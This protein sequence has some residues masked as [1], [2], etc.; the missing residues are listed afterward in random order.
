MK[1]NIDKGL[2]FNGLVPFPVSKRFCSD[3]SDV[4]CEPLSVP[5]NSPSQTCPGRI[6]NPFFGQNPAVRRKG[7][8]RHSN[9]SVECCADGAKDGNG[10]RVVQEE[11]KAFPIQLVQTS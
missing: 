1:L 8:L 10:A 5:A 3:M 7:L 9:D 2:D 11:A 6:T 4:P